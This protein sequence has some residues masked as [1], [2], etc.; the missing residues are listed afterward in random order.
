[1]QK[2]QVNL[3]GAE[4]LERSLE[5]AADVVEVSTV[6]EKPARGVSTYLPEL[7]ADEDFVTQNA[8]LVEGFK[9]ADVLLVT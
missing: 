5:C 4:R 1:M 2:V 7:H 8:G 6:D 9:F 3:L